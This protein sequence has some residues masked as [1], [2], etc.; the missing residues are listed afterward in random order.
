MIELLH[1]T[2]WRGGLLVPLA[3]VIQ[4]SVSLGKLDLRLC[5]SR[6]EASNDEFNLSSRQSFRPFRGSRGA[7]TAPSSSGTMMMAR[8]PRV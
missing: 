5:Q 6:K 2:R 1:R 7:T 3:R 8:L 4:P